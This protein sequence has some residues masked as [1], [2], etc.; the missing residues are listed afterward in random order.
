MLLALALT[1]VAQ[2]TV[3]ID[4]GHPSEVGR[5]TAGKSVSEIQV[6]WEVGTALR[7]VLVKDGYRVVMTKSKRDQ[8]VTNRKRAE[9]A[10]EAKAD[11]MLRLHC[12]AST[13]RGYAIYYPGQRGTVNGFTGPSMSVVQFS[14]LAAYAF[15]GAFSRTIGSRLQNNGVKTDTQTSIGAKQGALTGSIYS[16]RPVILVEMVVLT[17]PK[18]EAFISS[19]A[20][21]QVMV[22]ALRQG[23]QAAVPIVRN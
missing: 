1:L 20:G 6:A 15:H 19:K 12:D 18:D 2:R 16:E 8:V 9:I 3:C 7:D 5:G 10:N 14:S 23:V 11:L 13:D 22:E 17:N 4:P 21:K